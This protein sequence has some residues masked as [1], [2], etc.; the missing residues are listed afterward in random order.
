MVAFAVKIATP[1]PPVP[2]RADA[3]QR[4][5]LRAIVE[6]PNGADLRDLWEQPAGTER[7]TEAVRRMRAA[8]EAAVKEQWSLVARKL[9]KDIQARVA[10]QLWINNSIVVDFDVTGPLDAAKEQLQAVLGWQLLIAPVPEAGPLGEPIH[11][12]PRTPEPPTSVPW[13]LDRLGAPEA[14]AAGHRGQGIRI[15]SI[16]MGVNVDHPEIAAAYAGRARDGSV[17]HNGHYFDPRGNATPGS[18]PCV[19]GDHG[20]MTIAHAVGANVGVAPGATFDAAV[21]F[22]DEQGLSPVQN[23]LQMRLELLRSIQWMSAPVGADGS[24]NPAAAPHI[25]IDSWGVAPDTAQA[26]DRYLDSALRNVAAAGIVHV[27]AAGNWGGPGHLAY[28]ADLETVIAVGAVDELDQPVWGFSHG[29]SRSTDITKPDVAAPETNLTSILPAGGYRTYGHGGTSS[30]APQI[31]G[32][33]AVVNGALL[34][35]GEA[36]LDIR[37]ARVAL[38]ELSRDVY[39]PGPDTATGMG[40]PD[41]RRLDATLA[42][43]TAER[44]RRAALKSPI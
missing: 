18:P 39:L 13:N 10:E 4:T 27:A 21:V 42:T 6:L 33:L 30:G 11:S 26:T 15:G 29:P 25:V 38:R 36:P 9:P 32:V 7:V 17:D 37:D 1:T 2:Q 16:D 35:R 40:V 20:S 23:E 5:T 12:R 14:H 44:A 41:L 34:A 8:N 24:P 28:P 31:A 43:L 19:A 22:S 3:T